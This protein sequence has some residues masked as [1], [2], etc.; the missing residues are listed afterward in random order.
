M[1]IP[2]F[3]TVML[4]LLQHL[5]DGREHPNQETIEALARGFGLSKGELTELLP[6]G[7]QPVFTN[8][9]AWAKSHMKMAGLVDAPKRAVYMITD[10]GRELL[11]SK[12]DTI[13][14]NTLMQYPEYLEFRT[15]KRKDH[16]TKPHDGEPDDP[17]FSKLTPEELLDAAYTRIRQ[18]L[19]RELLEKVMAS[20]PQFFERLVVELLVAM[21][22][23]GSRQDAGRTIGRSGDGG[24]DGFIKEDR[25][26]LD[27]VY[28]QA[29]RWEGTVGRPEIHKFAGALQGQRAKKGVFIT[30]SSFS[31]EAENYVERIDNRIV[32][33]DGEALTDLMID[34]NIGVTGV[35]TYEIKRLDSDYFEEV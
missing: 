26:G 16:K 29:K 24:V 25:L 17:V 18:E 3:Q 19:S 2:D 1:S 33:I 12:P 13:N 9:V 20:P 34:F 11:A 27:V 28:V 15:R 21:G 8:R 7:T 5:S 31:K 30:T 32:L 6:S 4:P 23:G 22:Y 14:M 10:R 35:D